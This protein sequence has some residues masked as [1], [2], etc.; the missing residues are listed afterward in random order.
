MTD[1]DKN[2]MSPF[3]DY[4]PVFWVN[5]AVYGEKYIRIMVDSLRYSPIL[6]LVDTPL[7]Q[8]PVKMFIQS[9]SQLVEYDNIIRNLINEGG[10]TAK[11][12]AKKMKRIMFDDRFDLTKAVISGHKRQKR[13]PIK[14]DEFEL[15]SVST[16][17]GSISW[18]AIEKCVIARYARYNVGDEV[19]VMQPYNDFYDDGCDP[20]MFPDGA[21]WTNKVCALTALMPYHIHITKVWV[22]RLQDISDDD[23]IKEGL[24]WDGKARSFYVNRNDR[25]ISCTW[26]GDTPRKAFVALADRIFK[27]DTWEKN[28]FVFVYEFELIR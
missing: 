18:G 16:S 1:D 8:P 13:V 17:Y 19:A 28:P 5:E 20:R 3:K 15:Y 2:Q 25:L 27:K 4:L 26:L 21:G 9:L 12:T 14:L 22:E 23:C 6:L 24:E 11:K 10:V 7:N